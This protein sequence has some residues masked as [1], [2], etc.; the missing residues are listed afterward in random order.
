M[1]SSFL[2]ARRAFVAPHPE[3]SRRPARPASGPARLPEPAAADCGPKWDSAAATALL[4]IRYRGGGSR[5]SCGTAAAAGRTASPDAD[6][7]NTVRP[8]A[9]RAPEAP[10]W[11]PCGAHVVPAGGAR[12]PRAIARRLNREGISINAEGPG[13]PGIFALRASPAGMCHRCATAACDRGEL[14][15]GIDH[16]GAFPHRNP[17]QRE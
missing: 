7:R 2:P 10:M 9:A 1:I 12:S 8:A 6:A 5:R 11:C 4:R 3:P 14:L 16:Q 13:K 15:T 17:R